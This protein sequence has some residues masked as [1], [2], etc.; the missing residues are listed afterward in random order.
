ML[1]FVDWL[2]FQAMMNS[3]LLIMRERFEI[4]IYIV[5]WILSDEK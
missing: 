5:N 4:E 3:V 2:A 1:R